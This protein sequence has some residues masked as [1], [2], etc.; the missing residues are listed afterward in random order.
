MTAPWRCQVLTQP[1]ISTLW[2]LL[3]LR[4]LD[5]SPGLRNVW[6]AAWVAPTPQQRFK[7]GLGFMHQ[8]AYLCQFAARDCGAD[9]QIQ[10]T[11]LSCNGLRHPVGGVR[12][13]F[14]PCSVQ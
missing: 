2:L 1:A 7:V 4:A 8:P 13:T 6:R 14:L 11:L 10:R 3:L 9:L 12:R 5:P